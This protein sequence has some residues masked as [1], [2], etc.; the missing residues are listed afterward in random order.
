M[1][2][3]R[4]LRVFLATVGIGL[5]ICVALAAMVLG[6]MGTV[7]LTQ[8]VLHI[9]VEMADVEVSSHGVDEAGAVLGLLLSI[10]LMVAIALGVSEST[11]A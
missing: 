4:G 1:N 11:E 2:I 9:I 10:V 6:T 7:G 8:T 3:I 5:L